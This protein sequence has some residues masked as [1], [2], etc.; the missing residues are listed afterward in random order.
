MAAGMEL[1]PGVV[2]GTLCFL[3]VGLTI[4]LSPARCVL[5]LRRHGAILLAES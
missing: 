5:G 3:I 4:T 1:V 2:M